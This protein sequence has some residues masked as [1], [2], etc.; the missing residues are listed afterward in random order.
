MPKS[1]EEK[2]KREEWDFSDCPPG[3]LTDC[4]DFE[5]N[6]ERFRLKPQSKPDKR[7]A[8]ERQLE[9]L[10]FFKF[11]EQGI[12]RLIMEEMEKGAIK[13]GVTYGSGPLSEWFLPE[14]VQIVKS[15]KIGD[16]GGND[17]CR[18]GKEESLVISVDWA[19]ADERLLEAFQWWLKWSRP[20]DP[21][22]R[23]HTAIVLA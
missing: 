20:C 23:D 21:Q 16:L 14:W 12:P 7:S 5:Y 6:R 18:R 17:S 9:E 4:A 10:T 2:I 1:I 15:G 13:G 19:A 11:L 3:L 8:L 22:R